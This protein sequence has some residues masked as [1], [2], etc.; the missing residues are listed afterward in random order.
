MQGRWVLR[1]G[2]AG[3]TY[4]LASTM[5]L[6]VELGRQETRLHGTH[7]LQLRRRSLCIIIPRAKISLKSI[8]SRSL[9]QIERA[10]WEKVYHEQ[11]LGILNQSCPFL[12]Q[13]I[14]QLAQDGASRAQ[15]RTV[16]RQFGKLE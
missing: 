3:A 15:H 4:L 9:V 12:V 7:R 2:E 1:L 5:V 8:I 13:V 14:I 10:L 11:S 16:R 6:L